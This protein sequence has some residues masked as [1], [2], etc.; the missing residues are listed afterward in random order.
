[1]NYKRGFI[2][3][4][5][6]MMLFIACET[7]IEEPEGK[8]DVSEFYILSGNIDSLSFKDNTA[9]KTAYVYLLPANSSDP[10]DNVIQQ[11]SSVLD[12]AGKGSYEFTKVYENDYALFSYIDIDSSSA[13]DTDDLYIFHTSSINS[14]LTVD[15]TFDWP[16]YSDTD[17]AHFTDTKWS[18]K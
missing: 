3:T 8:P 18:V 13:F 15:T 12:D 5:I 2:I 4:V 7:D 11:R 16:I 9:G 1:M 14:D 6:V 17:T 10:T